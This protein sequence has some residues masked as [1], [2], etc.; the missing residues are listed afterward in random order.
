MTAAIKVSLHDYEKLVRERDMAAYRAVG[1]LD[2]A[3]LCCEIDKPQEAVKILRRARE[4]YEA[5]NHAL[6]Q[7]EIGLSL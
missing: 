7:A 3:I 5:A 2:A 6:K 1:S 4:H